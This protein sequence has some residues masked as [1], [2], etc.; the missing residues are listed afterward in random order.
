MTLGEPA[1]APNN[2]APNSSGEITFTVP[3][4]D[5]YGLW[6]CFQRPVDD[7]AADFYHLRL[8]IH[9]GAGLTEPMPGLFEQHFDAKFLQNA[10]TRSGGWR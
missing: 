2:S 4:P 1:P 5:G 6:C 3:C 8:M 10:A 9:H 7:I